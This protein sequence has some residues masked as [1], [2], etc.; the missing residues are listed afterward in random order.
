MPTPITPLGFAHT[1]SS[2]LALCGALVSLARTGVIAPQRPSGKIYMGGTALAALTALGIYQHGGFG[3]GHWLAVITL[4][5]LGVGALATW[6]A[7]FGRFAVLV[8]TVSLSATLLFT[9]IPAVTEVMTRL[10]PGAPLVTS[11]ESPELKWA[12]RVILL[13][14]IVGLAVQLRGLRRRAKA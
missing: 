11:F 14:C 1:V 12:Y 6:S 5:A 2:M 3:P 13:L 8:Q 4:L 10:P 7:L 9:A